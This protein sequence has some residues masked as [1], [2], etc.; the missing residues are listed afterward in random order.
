MIKFSKV[1]VLELAVEK[2][3]SPQRL[4][5]IV[6]GRFENQ[7]HELYCLLYLV[8]MIILISS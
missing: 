8:I 3:Y 7:L 1:N 6:N 5:H 2:A 4:L